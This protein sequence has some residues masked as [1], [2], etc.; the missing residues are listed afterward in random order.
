L[1]TDQVILF[2]PPVHWNYYPYRDQELPAV[3][4]RQGYR[5]IY[6]NPL[7]YR[8][9]EKAR[10]FSRVNPRP[11]VDGLSIID[12]STRFRKSFFLFLYENVLNWKAVKQY[13]PD[14]VIG[15]NHLTAVLTCL[16]CHYMRLR[17]IFDVTDDWELVDTSLAG[18]FYKWVIKRIMARFAYAITT[19]SHKQFL[20][21]NS[22]R[23]QH[24]R[25]IS[26]GVSPEIVSTLKNAVGSGKYSMEVNFI[27][28]LRDWYDFD[29]LFDVFKELPE[30]TLNIYGQGPLFQQL[31]NRSIGFANIHIHGNIEN[32]YIPA[33]L[34]R[35]RF[36]MLPLKS[37]ELN[38][39]TCPIKL[40][41]YWAASKAVIATP[42]A[43]VIRI[44][45]DALL[46][47]DSRESFL[48]K[49]RLLLY[50]TELADRLGKMGLRKIEGSHNY[51]SI[52]NQF[53]EFFTLP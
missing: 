32:Q 18:K 3:L 46:Y 19:T 1:E 5:C 4:A 40:L 47:A 6:L 42:V 20:Y 15:T 35:T 28:S 25:I 38:D 36:G 50:D 33:L 13:N 52:A 27:G 7:E 34:M 49:A 12:R 22:L 48:E 53:K 8:G 29:L 41:E 51:E 21:F 30:L 26:N 39:S 31:Q 43:E 37:N 16:I 45:G 10:R 2:I 23:K 24:T 11:D 17:F 44:G 9:C 14:V